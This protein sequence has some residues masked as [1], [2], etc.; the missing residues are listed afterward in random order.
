MSGLGD[1]TR[2]KP[3]QAVKESHVG[4]YSIPACSS[5]WSGA[6]SVQP[7]A[8]EQQCPAA[9]CFG[10]RTQAAVDVTANMSLLACPI[11]D[12]VDTC[13]SAWMKDAHVLKR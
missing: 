2:H 8:V 7:A 3:Y 13:H 12:F 4:C 5:E 10:S 9:R 6:F 11:F 1:T